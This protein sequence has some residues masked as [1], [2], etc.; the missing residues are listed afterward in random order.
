MILL[1]AMGF[2]QIVCAASTKEKADKAYQDNDFDEAIA[3]YEEILDTEGESAVIYYNL[4]NAYYKTKNIAKAVVNYERA[5][6]LSPGNAD[7]RFNLE[8]AR[9]RTVDQITPTAEVFFVT[10]YK[11]LINTLDEK[12]WSYIGIF[13]FIVCL[14]SLSFYIFGKKIWIK[15]AGFVVAV[16]L[17]VITACSN[18][19]ASQ[20]KDELVNRTSAIIMDPTVSVKST[21]D[22]NGTDLFVLHEG[23]KVYIDDDSMREWKEIRLEDGNVGWV[24]TSAIEV[25]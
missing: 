15:K 17:L 9:S 23:T 13:S 5:L 1:L 20:Q 12:S 2:T 4:G 21:P 25:I 11:S 8:M 19:F 3:K 10:W 18:L 24:K 6:L 22:E 16:V 7:I 14:I